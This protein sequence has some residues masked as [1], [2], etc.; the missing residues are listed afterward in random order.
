MEWID[1]GIIIDRKSK[2]EKSFIISIF[3][4]HHGKHLGLGRSQ[5]NNLTFEPGSYVN[6][7]WRARLEDHLGN[8]TLDL[9]KPYGAYA[10]LDPL[11][12]CVV[13]SLTSLLHLILPERHPYP[14]LFL[15]VNSLL[16]AIDHPHFIKM[17]IEFE[18]MLLKSLGY[19]LDLEKCALT[20]TTEDLAYISPKTGRVACAEAGKPYASQL[21][22]MPHYFKSVP[23][24]DIKPSDYEEMLAITGHFLRKHFFG[25]KKQD[26]PFSRQRLSHFI[27]RV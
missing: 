16:K 24:E 18:L 25:A 19:G 6:C 4:E 9:I 12:L 8:F 22:K 13:G 5:K 21:F 23:K 14:E 17:Y 15:C 1:Q 2:G 27:K 20:G 3:T 7:K 11:N 26:L 10:L